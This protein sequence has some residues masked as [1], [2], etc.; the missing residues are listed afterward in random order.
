MVSTRSQRKRAASPVQDA[1]PVNVKDEESSQLSEV[2]SPPKKKA[3]KGKAAAGKVKKEE[4]EEPYVPEQ[5]AEAVKAEPD[6]VASTPRQKGKAKAAPTPKTEDGGLGPKPAKTAG[7]LSRS[8][9]ASQLT[10][11]TES[12][13]RESEITKKKTIT[14][15]EVTK[16][17]RLNDKDIKKL[18]FESIIT[19]AG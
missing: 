1:A 10:L 8:R 5:E 7:E 12:T 18:E 14:K 19:A 17:Y 13:W 16:L 11:S 3:N 9:K 2:L 4:S 6:V 15:G